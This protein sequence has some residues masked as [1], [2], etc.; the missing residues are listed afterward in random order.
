MLANI[1]PEEE[2]QIGEYSV[3]AQKETEAAIMNAARKWDEWMLALSGTP[4]RSSMH[5]EG[6]PA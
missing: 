6:L 1:T 4:A 2:L 3:L 5:E